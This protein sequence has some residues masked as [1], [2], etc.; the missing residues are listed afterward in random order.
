MGLIG[1]SGSWLIMVVVGVVM[2]LSFMTVIRCVDC[3]VLRL[4]G[5]YSLGIMLMHK[6]VVVPLESNALSLY[7]QWNLAN[8]I[9]SV[10]AVTLVAAGCSLFASICIH[11]CCP[12]ILGERDV[13][14]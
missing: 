12:I 14:R 5:L 10:A 11:K 1:D 6:F 2:S 3:K 8:G 13:S 7:M 9:S 4:T